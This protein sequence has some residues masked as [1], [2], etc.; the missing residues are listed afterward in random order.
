MFVLCHPVASGGVF[1]AYNPLTF[2]KCNW[3]IYSVEI[4]IQK[5]AVPYTYT[6]YIVIYSVFNHEGIYLFK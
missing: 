3:V 2:E 4:Q 5:R 1:T 6:T